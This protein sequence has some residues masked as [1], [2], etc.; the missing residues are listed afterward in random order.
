[1]KEEIRYTLHIE[2]PAPGKYRQVVVVEQ[3]GHFEVLILEGALLRTDEFTSVQHDR[4]SARG[5]HRTR[6]AADAV[7]DEEMLKSLAA[8]WI[9][10]RPAER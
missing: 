5:L 9:L 7:A 4:E 10:V 1:M 3:A 2:S 8:G 6:D